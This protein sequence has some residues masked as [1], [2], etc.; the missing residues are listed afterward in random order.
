[1]IA[2]LVNVA[3]AALAT[4]EEAGR[5]G[6]AHPSIV[7]YQLFRAS[8]GSFVVACGT[9]RHFRALCSEV[10][11]RP[12]LADDPRFA[13]NSGRVEHR[14]TLVPL[15]EDLFVRRTRDEWIAT[16]T[17]A[18]VPCSPVQ[19]VLEAL[20]SPDA[21]PLI[22][23]LSHP[24]AGTYD[25][26]RHPVRLDGGQLSAGSAPPLLGADTERVLAELQRSRTQET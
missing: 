11:A 17:S 24:V 19:G 6:N 21:Q 3:Q 26:V 18:A 20:R 12:D 4:G 25:A 13:T 14:T 1:T 16:L 23:A 8:D 5:H 9:D 22:A 2:S 15:L 7:P 10:L